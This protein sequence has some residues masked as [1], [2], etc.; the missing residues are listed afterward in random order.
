MTSPP[1]SPQNILRGHKA[2]VHA[3]TF[4][5]NNARL[6][7]GD[8][9][10]Y[11][12]AWDLAIMRPRAVWRAHENAILGIEGWGNDKLIT[13]GRD[14]KLIVWKFAEEDEERLQ[15]STPLDLASPPPQPW[16]VHLLEVNTM[17][18][19]SFAACVG[20]PEGPIEELLIAVPNTLASESID[21]FQLPSQSRLY[22]I[23][24]GDKNG[25][26]MCL[27]LFHKAGDLF[28]IAAFENGHASV[29][30]LDATTN[31]WIMT[32]RAQA[33]TQPIL[34]LDVQSAGEYFL[35]SSADSIITK[36]PIPL[37]RQEIVQV[38]ADGST[39]DASKSAGGVS[40]LSS[41]LSGPSTQ[42]K[43]FTFKTQEWK[44]PIKTVNTKHS[45]QQSLSLRSDGKLF[46][47]AGWD[48]NVRV[49]SAK[50]LKEMAVLQWHKVG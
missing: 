2:Q 36:H 11:V 25:M 46:A 6:I 20:L 1:P 16:I 15:A 38:P 3:A 23:K 7:T 47:T 5:R 32:Y 29:H 44:D 48:S 21:I 31:D 12:I 24:P 22:T 26:A 27:S 41:A 50:T 39:A 42:G 14:H 40:A 4:I 45:G 37:T 19:C 43:A 35:T 17:N 30:R 34:S 13:H 33:H 18:F 10:G 49:Y 8:A 9:D 28:L